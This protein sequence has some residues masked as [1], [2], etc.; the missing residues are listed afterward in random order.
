MES[1]SLPQPVPPGLRLAHLDGL[2]GTAIAFVLIHHLVQPM[3][4][5]VPGTPSAYLASALTLTYT[6]VDLFF[7]LSGFLIGGILLDH[8]ASPRLMPAFF[9]RRAARILP[10]ACGCIGLGLGLHHL[11]LADG[12]PWPAAVYLF[13]GVNVWM[14]VAGQ[15]GFQLLAPLWSL[16]IE[17]QFYLVTPWIIRFLSP[18][19]LPWL[20]AGLIVAAPLARWLIL[21]VWPDGRFAASMLP[22]C[23]TDSLGLGLLGAWIMRQEAAQAWCRRH[24]AH[25]GIIFGAT[26]VGGLYL[27]RIRAENAGPAMAWGGYTVVAVFY[28]LILLWTE[29]YRDSGLTRALG[30]R[31]LRLLG[32]YSYFIYLFQGMIAGLIMNLCF[33]RGS[34]L[35]APPADLLQLATG[36]AGVLLAAAVSW[37][38]LEAP[39]LA[40]SRRRTAY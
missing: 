31:P 37:H 6:G 15:W 34:D 30:C 24:A 38:W 17:E 33:H 39:L 2:R 40:W 23:R 13:F 5:T 28:F 32:R 35:T 21:T 26:A 8:R 11:G 4:S 1:F 3:I 14:A 25:L 20:F 9:W 16:A 27:S 36:L 29:L 18:S 12:T 19:R 7:V 10:L 22:L